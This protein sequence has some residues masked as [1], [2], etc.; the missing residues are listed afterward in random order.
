MKLLFTKSLCENK[1]PG[2]DG[3]RSFP[4]VFSDCIWLCMI[5]VIDSN[6]SNTTESAVS[7]LTES[8]FSIFHLDQLNIH[9]L[10]QQQQHVN[11]SIHYFVHFLKYISSWLILTSIRH[12]LEKKRMRFIEFFFCIY[13]HL[14]DHC[15]ALS[16]LSMISFFF[17]FTS[18]LT[19]KKN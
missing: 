1:A 11:K 16:S 17:R 4:I 3:Y 10:I 19:I 5:P 13:M 15:S 8:Y 14:V 12:D 18:S 9:V 6:D 7:P 2:D